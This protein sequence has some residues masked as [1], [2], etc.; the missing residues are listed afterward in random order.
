MVLAST[1]AD[2]TGY[3][4]EGLDVYLWWYLGVVVA[5]IVILICIALYLRLRRSRPTAP[6]ASQPA[7]LP[8][9][10]VHVRDKT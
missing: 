5:P 9:A 6:E 10:R 4:G 2:G 7:E 3:V 8:R 1:R